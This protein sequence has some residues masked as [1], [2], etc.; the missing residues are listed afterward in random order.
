MYGRG[1]K[2][3]F[4]L[5]GG[6]VFYAILEIAAFIA[7]V[8]L[9]GA[10]PHLFVDVFTEKHFASV[11]EQ[12][13]SAFIEKSHD[14]LLGWDNRPLSRIRALN[15][16]G[17]KWER[18]HDRDGAREDGL[19]LKQL[20]VHSYG[21]SFTLCEEVN[22]DQTWQYKLEQKLGY[23]VRNFGVGG[24]GT[25][26]ALLKLKRHIQMGLVAPVTVLGIYEKNVDRTRT[27][28]RP[29]L[30]PDSANKLGF[31]PVFLPADNGRVEFMA[32]PYQDV[33]ASLQ[34]LRDTALEVAEHDYWASRKTVFE[35]SYVWRLVRL[36]AVYSDSKQAN[37]WEDAASFSVMRY[38]VDEFV[39]ATIEAG[40]VPILLFIP[41]KR[42]LEQQQPPTYT[43][44]KRDNASR[45]P[46]LL[47]VDIASSDFEWHRFHISSFKGHASPEGNEHIAEQLEQVIRGVIGTGAGQTGAA[48]GIL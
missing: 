39:R 20:L 22:N 18:S 47:M 21:D 37:L 43:A 44:F 9:A 24:Y 29:F 45:W 34:D 23:E 31:K 1:T 16:A 26:Q 3:F 32:N 2:I 35:F 6:F 4:Y 13:R 12:Y 42:T 48:A 28:F 17:E 36:L 7:L 40:S 10:R 46:E 30:K 15:V 41:D 33:A 11:S 14:P 5:V 27:L 38:I 19:P 25:D 8:I